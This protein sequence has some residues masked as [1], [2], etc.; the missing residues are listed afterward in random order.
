MG[1]VTLNVGPASGAQNRVPSQHCSTPWQQAV[2][3][4]QG[5][6]PRVRSFTGGWVRG[7]SASNSE[8]GEMTGVARG[9]VTTGDLG[10]MILPP[11]PQPSESYPALKR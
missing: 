11:V 3:G 1:R 10:V 4:G 2:Q 8:A 5:T 9:G 7:C 6:R